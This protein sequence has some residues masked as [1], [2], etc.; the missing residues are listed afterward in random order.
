MRMES[1]RKAYLFAYVCALFF[2]AFF[3]RGLLVVRIHS[4]ISHCVILYNNNKMPLQSTTSTQNSKRLGSQQQ[5]QK[6]KGP[7]NI[8]VIRCPDPEILGE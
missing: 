7:Y 1:P 5:A 6:G 3:R 8:S 2:S 4:R